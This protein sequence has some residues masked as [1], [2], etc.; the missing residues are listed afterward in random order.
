MPER[1]S[2]SFT[3][4]LP[5][6]RR[7]RNTRGA[8]VGQRLSGAVVI[9]GRACSWPG[10]RVHA[11]AGPNLYSYAYRP[12]P[13]APYCHCNGGAV[14]HTNSSSERDIGGCYSYPSNNSGGPHGNTDTCRGSRFHLGRRPGKPST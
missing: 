14:S 6:G 8:R 7:T 10:G 9:F 2:A 1:S 13:T 12:P 3:A 11:T 4:M 5:T